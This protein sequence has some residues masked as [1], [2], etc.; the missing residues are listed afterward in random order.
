MC[1]GF[2]AATAEGTLNAAVSVEEGF[3]TELLWAGTFDTGDDAK[4]DGFAALRGSGQG[5]ED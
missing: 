2:E 4:G 1:F 5:L 3:R